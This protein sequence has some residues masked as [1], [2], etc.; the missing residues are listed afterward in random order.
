MKKNLVPIFIICISL[1]LAA[2]ASSQ[3]PA[4][5]STTGGE[6]GGG[7]TTNETKKLIIAEPVHNVGYL[8][9]YAAM[10]EG[11]FAEEGLE[12][13]VITATGGG[14]ITSLVSGEVWANI[15][16]PE[17]NQMANNGS[18]DPIVSVVNVANRANVYLMAATGLETPDITNEEEFAEFLKGKTISAHRYGGSLNILTRWL[19][20]ELGL[21][22]E[23]DVVL[24][25]LADPAAAISLVESGKAQ[26]A[27][28]AEPQIKDGLEKGVWDEPFYKFTDLGDYPYSVLSVR[29][30]TIEEDPE[31]VQ[32]FVN[33]V[34]KGLKAIDED[35]ALAEEIFMKEFPTSDETSMKAAL[36]RAYEDELWSKDGIITEES[37]ALTMEVVEKT[38]IYT[39]GY[40]Y[41][42]LIDMQ[43][44]ENSE[45]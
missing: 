37:L 30:S 17:S 40:S 23:K 42:E 35:R 8:P 29:K 31:T 25:E 2:C 36:D 27:N 6:S 3:T 12:I 33:A 7:D 5:T 14:H 28:G 20:L 18:P 26:I 43:F 39:E 22:P 10:H 21:D 13:E 44:V 41:D 19:L 32:K 1:I 9:L 4:S 45:Q 34:M 15:G 11:Y 24:E 16:G 38:G